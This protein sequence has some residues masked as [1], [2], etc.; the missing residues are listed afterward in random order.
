MEENYKKDIEKIK[1]VLSKNETDMSVLVGTGF[2]KN[3]N[4]KFPTWEEL[5]RDVIIETFKS[6]MPFA[7]TKNKSRQIERIVR[8][9]IKEFGY[10]GV[11]DNYI[12]FKGY[13][14]SIDY[15]ID[16]Y[17][18]SR[19]LCSKENFSE[20]A[21]T[22]HLKLLNCGWNNIYTTNYDNL[23]EFALEK[24]RNLKQNYE[25]VYK[26]EELNIKSKKR[27]IKLH[28]NLEKSTLVSDNY[29]FDDD[30]KCHFIISSDDYIK[31]AERHDSFATL[32]KISLLQEHFCLIGF[33]G[34]DPNFLDWG[35]W[36]RN[37]L[38]RSK[39]KNDY[40][41]YFIDVLD[42]SIPLDRK[43]M[44]DNYGI[45]HI[46][47]KKVYGDKTPKELIDEF[48]DEINEEKKESNFYLREESKYYNLWEKVSNLKID[49]NNFNDIINK[50]TYEEQNFPLPT[51]KVI[52]YSEQ[53]VSKL[54]NFLSSSGNNLDLSKTLKYY[55]YLAFMLRQSYS[56][57][58]N[59]CSDENE[60][61][62]IFEA[63]KRIDYKDLKTKDEKYYWSEFL[64]SLLE[65]CRLAQDYINFNDM[66]DLAFKEILEKKYTHEAIYQ[67]VIFLASQLN[68]QEAEAIVNGWEIEEKS[69]YSWYFVK[70][71]YLYCLLNTKVS[72]E[73]VIPLMQIAL[74]ICTNNQIKT[75]IL[76]LI[77]YY[78]QSNSFNINKEYKFELGVLKS[79]GFYTLDD[80][81]KSFFKYENK[82]SVMPVGADR[83]TLRFNL[84]NSDYNKKFDYSLKLSGLLVKAGLPPVIHLKYGVTY[85]NQTD[86]FDLNEYTYRRFPE[87]ILFQSLQ[88]GQNDS[89]HKFTDSIMQK[90]VNSSVIDKDR[91]IDIFKN[92]VAL[93]DYYYSQQE[94]D[95]LSVVT[96]AISMLVDILEYSTWQD[97]WLKLWKLQKEDTRIENLFY[98]KHWNWEKQICR[99][100]PFVDNKK[101][102]LIRFLDPK[103]NNDSLILYHY[104]SSLIDY[105]VVKGVKTEVSNGILRLIK[106]KSISYYILLVIHAIGNSINKI[107]KNKI[108]KEILLRGVKGF[109]NIFEFI[110]EIFDGDEQIKEM[111]HRYIIEN[112]E[113][114]VFNSGIRTNSRGYA[115]SLNLNSLYENI[116][117]TIKEINE[118]YIILTR[119]LLKMIDFRKKNITNTFDYSDSNL[120]IQMKEF[121][122]KYQSF[123]QDKSNYKKTTIEVGACF[124]ELIGN[125]DGDEVLLHKD[126]NSIQYLLD[127]MYI[128]FNEYRK[129]DIEIFWSL[130]LNKILKMETPKFENCFEFMNWILSVPDE[131]I[132]WLRNYNNLYIFILQTFYNRIERHELD[133]EDKEFI[134]IQN[135]KLASTLK[136]MYKMKLKIIQK[137]LDYK[138]ESEFMTVRKMKMKV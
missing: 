11:V 94:F 6:E 42:N 16:N 61:K 116:T 85:I 34:N 29:I 45:K 117:F 114:L 36:V 65:T 30:H 111:I 73:K 13:R 33:S 99:M 66:Y 43:L 40:K 64:I 104:L 84:F 115:F 129:E 80:L 113:T 58:S 131:K 52:F 71:A 135:I 133:L 120:L 134:I 38:K 53:M 7:H 77:L 101:E 130:L 98:R 62:K 102:C 112:K 26:S 44:F 81:V 15:Y 93:W 1:D 128:G 49:T 97:F 28:G 127:K 87:V 4:A 54:F 125:I 121:L 3:A 107:A 37:I 48:L 25:F 100:L 103:L 105:E 68:F 8:S 119:S 126:P 90:I 74:K 72:K 2:S 22:S 56:S 118:I 47:L 75:F 138:N 57:I 88:F 20:T 59:L 55:F 92:F 50:L 17:F 89:D 67:K 32:M 12:K 132:S 39:D 69:E 63:F 96:S 124:K 14:E 10:L 5:L 106:E 109:E 79:K 78:E 108:K 19:G 41:I 76:E 60:F 123:L 91:K 137:W 110:F 23:F 136:S 83:N 70:K 27:I 9:K 82:R 21:L 122:A 46:P 24:D 51:Q 18:R 31:Y 86:W 35:D 95:Q